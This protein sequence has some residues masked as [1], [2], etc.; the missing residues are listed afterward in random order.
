MGS[1]YKP[2]R[3]VEGKRVKYA[4]YRISYV[5]EQGER[6]SEKAYTDKAASLALLRKREVDVE[7]RRAGLPVTE[8]AHKNKKWAAFVEEFAAELASRGSD[9]DG[10][11]VRDVRSVL[12][13]VGAALEWICIGDVRRE[14][15]TKHLGELAAAGLAP[16]TRKNK[17][18]I[19]KN[20]L[21]WCVEQSWIGEN[22]LAT[23]KAPKVGQAGKRRLRRAYSRDE[24]ARLL[25]ATPEPRRTLYLIASL[26]G[27]RRVE[28]ARMEGQDFALDNNRPRWQ[29]R[30]SVSK[31]KRQD[32]VP[33]VPDL[34]PTMA[35]LAFLAPRARLVKDGLGCA[36]PMVETLYDDLARAKIPRI[37]AH[38]RH[39]DFHSFRYTFCRLMGEVL[40]IQLVK[41]L[42]RHRTI[43]LT[44][45]LYGQLGIDDLGEAV[46][47][48]PPLGI[49]QGDA[50]A[51][52]PAADDQKSAGVADPA[53][54]DSNPAEVQPEQSAQHAQRPEKPQ[55]K[56]PRSRGRKH[57]P[58]SED[59]TCHRDSA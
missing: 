59:E 9:P 35:R 19:L 3:E 25:A 39:A 37:D 49:A 51:Q 43:S 22:P 15:V 38:G 26:S 36:V 58:D 5:N 2:T 54:P 27:F 40:P 18:S 1:V 46:W 57:G 17:L 52:E 34:L 21:N 16:Q 44:A 47:K 13:S 33:I 42:M 4:K 30:A 41:V 29:A 56:K 23:V 6:V 8:D 20:A 53:G 12:T 28:L 31:N 45:D 24:L 32:A 55:T 7:R 10:S 50:P 14:A 11:H 48:L